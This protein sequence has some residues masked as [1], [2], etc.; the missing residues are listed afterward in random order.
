MLGKDVEQLFLSHCW[1]GVQDGTASLEDNLAV[2][3]KQKIV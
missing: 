3:H 2:S 1:S